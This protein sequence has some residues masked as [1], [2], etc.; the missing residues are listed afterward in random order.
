M[1]FLFLHDK[2]FA[3]NQNLIR[4]YIFKH[5]IRGIM[6][7]VH[8]SICKDHLDLVQKKTETITLEMKKLIDLHTKAMSS[9]WK[10]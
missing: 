10:L 8:N 4:K 6:I 7:S 5:L 9:N 1:I 3:L 2:N